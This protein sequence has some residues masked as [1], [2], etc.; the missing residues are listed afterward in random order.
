[1]L[2]KKIT[3]TKCKLNSKCFIT[4]TVKLPPFSDELFSGTLI[5][6]KLQ[7]TF[8]ILG[9]HSNGLCECYL[10]CKVNF[11]EPQYCSWASTHCSTWIQ[12]HLALNSREPKGEPR[13]A[14]SGAVWASPIPKSCGCSRHAGYNLMKTVICLNSLI[15]NDYNAKSCNPV[16]M[17]HIVAQSF[18]LTYCLSEGLLQRKKRHLYQEFSFK[19]FQSLVYL[20]FPAGEMGHSSYSF[21]YLLNF[22]FTWVQYRLLPLKHERLEGVGEDQ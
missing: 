2:K 3:E 15:P 5:S 7:W 12:E 17:Y 19:L 14:K 8:H 21:Y 6:I 10:F 20:W 16:T 13:Q 4:I 9:N 11:W 18:E 22:C 1:M